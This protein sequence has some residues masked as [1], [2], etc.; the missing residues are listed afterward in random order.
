M[1]KKILQLIRDPNKS[2]QI[3]KDEL[4]FVSHVNGVLQSYDSYKFWAFIRGKMYTCLIHHILQCIDF[5]NHS[6]PVPSPPPPPSINPYINSF[7]YLHE[8]LEEVSAK[9]FGEQ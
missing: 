3:Q 1:A 5:Q 6:C 4:F 9:P 7:N 8:R 2:K